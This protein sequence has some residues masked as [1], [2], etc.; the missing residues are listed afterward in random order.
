MDSFTKKFESALE[1]YSKE[2][3][4][5]SRPFLGA[6]G[7]K[8][9]SA[10]CAVEVMDPRMDNGMEG[11]TKELPSIDEVNELFRDVPGSVE[12]YCCVL[13]IYY[14]EFAENAAYYVQSLGI[15][16]LVKLLAEDEAKFEQIENVKIKCF[17]RMVCESL[18][19]LTLAYV[20][21][22]CDEEDFCPHIHPSLKMKH[23]D[24]RL[25]ED[26]ENSAEIHL[27]LKFQ[28]LVENPDSLGSL[29]KAI[30]ST[31]LPPFDL[32]S[33]SKV[34]DLIFSPQFSRHYWP[35]GPAKKF[36]LVTASDLAAEN[37]IKSFLQRII[38][39]AD[40][41]QK[42]VIL[43]HSNN[44]FNPAV[45]ISGLS[46]FART[47]KKVLDRVIAR[48]FLDSFFTKSLLS[49]I[50]SI[51]PPIKNIKSSDLTEFRNLLCTYTQVISQVF[52]RTEARIYRGLKK[53]VFPNLSAMLGRALEMERSLV[54][55]K[56]R[57]SNSSQPLSLLVLSFLLPLMIEN[58]KVGFACDL[59]EKPF[60][61]SYVFWL[62]D[63]FTGIYLST[64]LKMEPEK[65]NQSMMTVLGDTQIY[66]LIYN[67][68]HKISFALSRD[69]KG[70]LGGAGS[71]QEFAYQERMKCFICL[72]DF[73]KA[74][75]SDYLNA[76]GPLKAK[77]TAT[78]LTES[79]DDLKKAI[80]FLSNQHTGD[81]KKSLIATSVN[82]QKYLKAIQT[83]QQDL[84]RVKY[85]NS[86]CKHLPHIQVSN[87]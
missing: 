72:K 58:L 33:I 63:Y 56:S 28:E 49:L 19:G 75:Y 3:L 51:T 81:L 2:P 34:L 68:M 38:T 55:A 79:M 71:E 14:L 57:S 23:S 46:G 18:V 16:G 65:T 12:I 6:N 37:P 54:Q 73:I 8:L 78:I 67:T 32:V 1:D 11:S 76:L 27:L 36:K 21:M 84:S 44:I 53:F 22:V 83:S 30:E 86:Y 47:T 7:F 66:K 64:L 77:D 80:T 60:E 42:D 35:P 31:S 87:I 20:P 9:E 15:C 10:M 69:E 59:Y 39:T 52:L 26:E 4:E 62:L 50:A 82:I 61:F 74:E 40:Q 48:K 17:T 45:F 70:V 25:V 29:K 5:E 85:L 13:F 43:P 41:I 24:S